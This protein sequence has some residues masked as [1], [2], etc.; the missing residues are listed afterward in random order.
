MLFAILQG[1]VKRLGIEFD[2]ITIDTLNLLK[3]EFPQME[4]VDITTAT[5]VRE[6]AKVWPHGELRNMMWRWNA[7]CS[8]NRPATSISA[9]RTLIAPFTIGARN[10]LF[11]VPSAA[12]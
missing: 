10:C 11:R 5:M 3:S 12:M 7:P 2:H 6:I 4:F 9:I 8:A 1:R